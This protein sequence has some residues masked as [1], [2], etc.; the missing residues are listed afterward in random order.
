MAEPTVDRCAP[1]RLAY[2]DPPLR[3]GRVLLR[4]WRADDLPAI[5]RATRDPAIRRFS[6][7]PEPFDIGAVRSRFQES[8]AQL[9]AG[10]AMR[11]LIVEPHDESGLCGAIA[12][13]DIDAHRRCGEIGYWLAAAARG[14]GLA[15]RA[16]GLM[17]GW[18]LG[19]LGLERLLAIP[20]A[21]NDASRQLLERCGFRAGER[22]IESGRAVAPYEATRARPIRAP[23]R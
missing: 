18:A 15:S 9:A 5:A 2:P 7:L 3:D 10:T 8:P 17:S 1:R 23:A 6:H 21:E 14:R 4:P 19:E 12:I 11:M 22:R 16:V 20:D 13:F